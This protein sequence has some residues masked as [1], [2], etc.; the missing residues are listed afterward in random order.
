MAPLTGGASRATA[1]EGN[2]RTAGIKARLFNKQT[3]KLI[4]NIFACMFRCA[5]SF[6]S[7]CRPFCLAPLC[8]HRTILESGKS[9]KLSSNWYFKS[10]LTAWTHLL[11]VST[12]CGG[13]CLPIFLKNKAP[14]ITGAPVC[15]CKYVAH[16]LM[17]FDKSKQSEKTQFWHIRFK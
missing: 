15:S 10:L 6:S 13:K 17:P 3:N 11:Y 5:P 4:C 7:H 16:F 2:M 9:G 12:L 14:T 8:L 1:R